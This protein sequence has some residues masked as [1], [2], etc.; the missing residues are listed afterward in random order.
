MAIA[1]LEVKV[2]GLIRSIDALTKSV[3]HCQNTRDEKYVTKS[4]FAP[5]RNLIYGMV[6]VICAGALGA[7]GTI[8]F[9]HGRE[10]V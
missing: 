3:R 7:V 9:I 4:E 8:L 10:L 2:D 1:Q 5:I 6:A